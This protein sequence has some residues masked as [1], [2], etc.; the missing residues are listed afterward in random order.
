[1]GGILKYFKVILA[2]KDNLSKN[3]LKI[4]MTKKMKLRFY[5]II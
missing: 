2:E 4:I 1:M 3:A 5:K